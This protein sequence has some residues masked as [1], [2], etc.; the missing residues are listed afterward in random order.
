MTLILT[1]S[2]FNLLLLKGLLL[3]YFM[4]KNIKGG[5]KTKSISR[6]KQNQIKS[7]VMVYP[8]GSGQFIVQVFKVG[9]Q[10]D[11]WAFDPK[12]FI[13]SDENK[14]LWLATKRSGGEISQP[15]TIFLVEHRLCDTDNAKKRVDV[16][17]VY[18][19]EQKRTL[20]NEG[21]LTLGQ[22]VIENETIDEINEV[23]E[24]EDN[25]ENWLEDL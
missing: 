3:I 18:N 21:Y 25:G 16:L 4:V 1:I 8:S 23:E 2:R 14:I 7:S 10:Y 11:Y 17:H 12:L 22:S 20:E 6:K 9:N 13:V 5:S 15:G 19:D 24:I